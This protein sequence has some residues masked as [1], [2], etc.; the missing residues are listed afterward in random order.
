QVVVATHSPILL[1]YPHAQI[2]SFDDHGVNP[3]EYEAT[4]HYRVAH[5]VLTARAQVLERV[6]TVAQ[7]KTARSRIVGAK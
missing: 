2:L 3:I 7:P 4:E 6:L 1:A 5:E